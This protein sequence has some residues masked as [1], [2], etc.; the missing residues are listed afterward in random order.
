MRAK[1]HIHQGWAAAIRSEKERIAVAPVFKLHL[2]L[3]LSQ[4]AILVIGSR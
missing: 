3:S 2:T 1:L 4:Y